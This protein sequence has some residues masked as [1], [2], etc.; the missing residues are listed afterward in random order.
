MQK[1][2]GIILVNYN[3][4]M[5]TID[6][7]N[8]L[9]KITYSNYEI[10]VVDNASTATATVEQLDVLRAKC[11]YIE[12]KENLGFSGGNNIGIK[13]AIDD[14]CDYVL[15]LNND[16]TVEPDFLDIL[17]AEADAHPEAGIVCGKIR[18]YYEP[19][20]IWFAGGEFD[21]KKCAA[22][23]TLWNE[24]DTDFSATSREIT[25]A[26]G[27]LMLMPSSLIQNLGFMNE[28]FFLYCE[29]TDLCCKVLKEG[30]TIRYC[31]SAVIYHK[32][33]AS[34]GTGSPLSQYY[35]CRNGLII[36]GRY[37]S[38]KLYSRMYYLYRN[39]KDICTGKKK[40]GI[41]FR[42]YKDYFKGNLGKTF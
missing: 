27:C 18:F 19:D 11:I 3:G 15:L 23:H 17:V 28:E 30:Y 2:V 22:S 6:C 5:D 21:F 26:T 32:V 7:V 10:I 37:S 29:D 8:S 40:I 35:I 12:G 34:T 38:N 41:V 31:N 20:K 39:I 4:F 25:F 33:N 13:K 9:D 1:K 16:T 14:Q 36:I 42:A 24:V